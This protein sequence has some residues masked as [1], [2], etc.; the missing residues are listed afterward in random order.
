M[1]QHVLINREGLGKEIHKTK[2]NKYKK[3]VVTVVFYRILLFLLLTK[4]TFI[5]R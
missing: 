3:F 2:Q 5:K 4:F 1:D